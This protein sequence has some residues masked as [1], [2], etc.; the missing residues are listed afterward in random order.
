LAAVLLAAPVAAAQAPLV[1]AVLADVGGDLVTASDVALARALGLFGFPEPRSAA[2]R[3]VAAT[4]DAGDVERMIGV[5]LVL[6]EARRLGM[7]ATAEES[8][9]AWRALG[10]RRGGAAALET[11]LAERGIEGGWARRVVRDDR[12]WRHFVEQRFRVFAFVMP[13]ELAATLGPG[14]HPPEVEERL[15]AELRER[16]TRERLDA[17]LA[18]RLRDVRVRRFLDA[19]ERLWLPFE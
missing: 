19:D 14:P 6:R 17:W 11:W 2:A 7:T 15:R 9:E 10:E 13:D 16:Q 4:L 5:R 1:D 8:D 12:D 18:Q 3:A